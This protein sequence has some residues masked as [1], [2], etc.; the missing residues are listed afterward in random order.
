M[1]AFELNADEIESLAFEA[2][3]RSYF[4]LGNTLIDPLKAMMRGNYS[5][6]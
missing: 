6:A 3:L 2:E 4:G 1:A 5:A